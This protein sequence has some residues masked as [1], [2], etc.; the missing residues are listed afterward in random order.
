MKQATGYITEDGTFFERQE[1]ASLHEAEQRLRSRLVEVNGT[2]DPEKFMN[3][4]LGVMRELK[5]FVDAYN[6]ADTTER[7]QQDKDG[8]AVDDSET[9]ASD[10]SIGHVSPTEEDLA[11]LLKLPSRG[12]RNV[13]D[14][15]SSPRP[16]E[17]SKRRPKHGP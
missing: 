13:P 9:P 17:V 6:A 1:E 3:L 15:G 10:A 12:P 8:E 2:V 7:N 14:V 16:K 4:V 5:G 11:S